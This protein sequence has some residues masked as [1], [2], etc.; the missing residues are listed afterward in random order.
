MEQTIEGKIEERTP[1]Q[2]DYR[3]LANM[4]M[5]HA[6]EIAVWAGDFVDDFGPDLLELAHLILRKSQAVR[7]VA[8]GKPQQ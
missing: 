5:E 3:E 4:L 8:L 2:A 1:N 6:G 7:R